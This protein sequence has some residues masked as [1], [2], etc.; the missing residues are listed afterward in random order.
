MALLGLDQLQISHLRQCSHVVR[1]LRASKYFKVKNLLCFSIYLIS[2]QAFGQSSNITF[3]GKTWKPP[4]SLSIPQGW[5][6]E[7]FL[8]PPSFA[9]QIQYKGIEDI[10]F[11]PGWGNAK[12]PEYWSYTFLWFLDSLPK[13]NKKI[14]QTN[15]KKYYTGLIKTNLDPK[16]IPAEGILETKTSIRKIKTVNGDLKTFSGTIEM[17]DYMQQKPIVLNCLI[18]FKPYKS[19]NKTIVFYELSPKLFSDNIWIS[20]NKLW[21]DFAFE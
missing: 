2:F 7:R 10:R 9:A 15:L 8:V 11:T 12:S 14:L 17:L 19:K 3:D 20:L 16:K 6:V 13:I 4:Y 21:A 5:D 18:H 1:H